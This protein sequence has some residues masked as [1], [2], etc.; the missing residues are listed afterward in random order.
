MNSGTVIVTGNFELPDK[1][2]AAHRVVNNSKLLRSLGYNAVFLGTNR[3]EPYFFGIKQ[4]EY[5]AGFDMYEQAYPRSVSQ[6]VS[7]IFDMKN[8]KTLVS[9]YPDTVALMLYNT[10]FATVRAARKAFASQGIRILYDCTEWNAYTEGSFVKRAVKSIDS[11]LIEHKLPRQC[12]GIVAVSSVMEQEYGGKKPLIVLPPLVDTEDTIW[13]QEIEHR[14]RFNFC[15]AGSPSDKD[16]LDL[17]LQAFSALP[18]GA[19]DLRIIG[20]TKEEFV[21]HTPEATAFAEHMG[22]TFTGRLTHYETVREILSCDCFVFLREPTRRNNA[23]FPTKFAEAFTCGVPV[24]TTAVSDVPAYAD[25]KCIILPDVSPSGIRE[26]MQN[27]ISRGR[28]PSVLRDTFDYTKHTDAF[29]M[30]LERVLCKK[31]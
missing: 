3:E 29:H 24:I 14:H 7:E 6:W 8:L 4:R 15:Y 20:V 21:S 1:N 22:I 17:L 27:V 12:D 9:K 26:A 13:K 18:V 10:Q 11:R 23:G 30:W 19:A 5:G 2:A 25:E 31:D 16:R 28:S